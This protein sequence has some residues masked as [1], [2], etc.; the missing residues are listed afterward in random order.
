[1]LKNVEDLHNTFRYL[2]MNVCPLQA[3]IEASFKP[4]RETDFILLL[5]KCL[6]RSTINKL[7]NT[8]TF[9]KE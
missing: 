8:Q 2:K 6:Y 9:V 4:F 7:S 3:K 1:M 5:S